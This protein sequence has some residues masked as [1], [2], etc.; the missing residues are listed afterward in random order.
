MLDAKFK[1]NAAAVR[2]FEVFTGT[3]RRRRWPLDE[4]AR[5]VGETLAPGAVV[6]EVARRHGISPQQL[7]GWRRAARLRA[8]D[9]AADLPGFVPAMLDGP[10]AMPPHA[11]GA[12]LEIIVG[13]MIA[14]IPLGADG[15]TLARIVQALKAAP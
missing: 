5:I 1:P 3:G 8:I 6:S 4:K 9:G 15:A 14:R 7:F 2:R 10:T 13:S 11:D 12:V